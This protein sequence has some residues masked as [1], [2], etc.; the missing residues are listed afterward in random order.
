MLTRTSLAANDPAVD[1]SDLVALDRAHLIHPVAPW[2][3]HE[4][5]GVTILESGHGAWLRD[6][7]GNELLDAFAGLWCVNIGYGN[8][9]VVEAAAAQMRK[10]PYATGYFHYGS[11]PA[12]R[13]A[14]KLVEIT[15][16]SL[17]HVYLTLGGSEAI[18]AAARL[19]I[20][21]YNVT[22]RPS[23]KHF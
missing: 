20:Q 12:I 2:R 1:T 7:N 5:R 21:Y 13:L 4:A 11:E 15:P 6:A 9:R 16:S 18:D 3:K 8:E 14:A 19:I 22:A 10:L 17:Q 23:K